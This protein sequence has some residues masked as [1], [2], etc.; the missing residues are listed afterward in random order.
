MGCSCGRDLPRSIE[1]RK[2]GSIIENSR[3][4]NNNFEL[5]NKLRKEKCKQ[6]KTKLLNYFFEVL[7]KFKSEYGESPAVKLVY[8][9]MV[10]QIKDM[11]SLPDLFF[12]Q[13]FSFIKENKNINWNIKPY[14]KIKQDIEDFFITNP[15]LNN[16]N[17]FDFNSINQ[18]LPY[19]STDLELV[20]AKTS[21]FE[22][23]HI[24]VGK[25][26]IVIIILFLRN[27]TKNFL[28]FL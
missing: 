6:D 23:V 18:L 10:K 14:S 20:F 7:E 17:G 13:K 28:T 12:N 3:G 2:N 11:Y 15:D 27:K 19:E 5:I 26:D 25:D 21:N 22:K 24:E 9:S 16:Y 8:S 1:D 4:A